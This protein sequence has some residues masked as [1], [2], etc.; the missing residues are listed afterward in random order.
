MLNSAG[1]SSASNFA[2]FLILIASIFIVVVVLRLWR[3]RR[4]GSGHI[5]KTE[6]ERTYCPVCAAP[7]DAGSA[8]CPRCKADIDEWDKK[9]FTD[10]LINALKHPLSDVR[11][12]AI[13][14]LGKRRERIAE[15][16]LVDCAMAYPTD[17]VQGLEIVNSLLM[18]RENETSSW[19][20]EKLAKDHPAH[21]VREAAERAAKTLLEGAS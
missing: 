4:D 3:A 17:V 16:A 19:A 15:Q 7:L 11:M 14:V 12:R 10:K 2:F 21:A 5:Q 6:E 9:N 8:G 18:I 13:I 20:L 1:I